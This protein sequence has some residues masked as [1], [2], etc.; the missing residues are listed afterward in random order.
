VRYYF[1]DVENVANIFIQG[2]SGYRI[3]HFNN[4]P[5]NPKGNSSSVFYAI[6]AGPV[7]YFN[8]SVGLEFTL[9]WSTSKVAVDDSKVNSL[10]FGIG[11]Q[12]HLKK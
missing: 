10:K 1:L 2:K 9:G 4:G 6:D 8:S 11:F 3:N 12:I 5:S 7:I